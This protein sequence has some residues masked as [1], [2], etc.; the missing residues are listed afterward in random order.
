MKEKLSACLCKRQLFVFVYY[1][2]TSSLEQRTFLSQGLDFSII[3]DSEFAFIL[4][5][6]KGARQL[7]DTF[8]RFAK[9]SDSYGCRNRE[10]DH[11]CGLRRDGCSERLDHRPVF[12]PGNLL[13]QHLHPLGRRHKG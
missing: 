13:R 2:L 1:R 5:G 6:E 12:P 11:S 8:F 7:S 3:Q 4:Y 9:I 10:D